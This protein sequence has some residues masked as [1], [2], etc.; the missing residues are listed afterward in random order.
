MLLL[1]RLALNHPDRVDHRDLVLGLVLQLHVI[2]AYPSHLV[3]ALFQSA[4]GLGPHTALVLPVR[5]RV[6][7][8]FLRH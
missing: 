4:L 5:R 1:L 3:A 7:D 2:R 6:G 8:F